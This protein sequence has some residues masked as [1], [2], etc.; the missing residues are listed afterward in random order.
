MRGSHDLAVS[1]TAASDPGSLLGQV[2]LLPGW[3]G[4]DA[5]PLPQPMVGQT[6]AVLEEY[7]AAGGSYQEVVLQDAGHLA[8]LEKPVT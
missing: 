8:Y 5:F 7:A 1:D 3:P 2:G 6:R 4:A